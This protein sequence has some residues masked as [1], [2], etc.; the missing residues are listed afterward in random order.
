MRQNELSKV[1]TKSL[2]HNRHFFFQTQ[3]NSN[4]ISVGEQEEC[5]DAE[6][7]DEEDV[8]SPNWKNQKKHVFILSESG[9]PVYSRYWNFYIA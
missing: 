1:S 4:S 8:N 2:P 5:L 6:V 3:V 9:K 7:E